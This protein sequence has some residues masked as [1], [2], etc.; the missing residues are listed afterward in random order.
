MGTLSEAFEEYLDGFPIR[1][2]TIY[3]FRIW[4]QINPLVF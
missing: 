3:K 1:L 2:L 4:L